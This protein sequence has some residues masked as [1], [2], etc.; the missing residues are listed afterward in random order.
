MLTMRQHGMGHTHGTGT[1]LHPNWTQLVAKQDDPS[2]VI[3][4]PTQITERQDAAM[5]Y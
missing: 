3:W 5:Y 2:N 1:Y 4:I